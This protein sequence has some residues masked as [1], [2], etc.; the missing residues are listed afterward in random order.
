MKSYKRVRMRVCLCVDS[1]VR[2][3]LPDDGMGLQTL[4]HQ[5][6]RG[7]VSPLCEGPTQK[8]LYGHHVH[9]AAAAQAVWRLQVSGNQ[10]CVALHALDLLLPT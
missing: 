1:G 8:L 4:C 9:G 7:Q 3:G 10:R 6:E 5:D 2:E